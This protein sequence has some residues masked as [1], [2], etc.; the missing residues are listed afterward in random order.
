M[1]QIQ[2]LETQLTPFRTIALERFNGTEAEAL[3]KLAFQINDLESV[4]STLQ[5]YSA[6]ATYDIQGNLPGYGPGSD[7]EMHT[8]LSDLLKDCFTNLPNGHI[9]AICTPQTEKSFWMRLI[10]FP[11]FRFHITRL[12][13]VIK[14]KDGQIGKTM[15]L[16]H[17]QF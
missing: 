17:S 15:P 9:Q 16:R 10:N 2:L 13:I 11:I 7:I 12:H 3:S 6:I 8:P 4:V 5:N 1:R 14:F